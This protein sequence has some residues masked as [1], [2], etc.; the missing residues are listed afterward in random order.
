MVEA[1]NAEQA[2]Y[3]EDRTQEVL[4]GLGGRS[5]KEVVECLRRD[6]RDFAAGAPQSDDITLLALR[7]VHR[8]EEA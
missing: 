5:A 1:E 2:L 3:G 8:P 7:Y 6:V 4:S